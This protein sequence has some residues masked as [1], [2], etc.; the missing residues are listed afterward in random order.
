MSSRDH[1]VS[2]ARV[3]AVDAHNHLGKWL[4][5]GEWAIHDVDLLLDL[6][7]RCNVRAIVNLDGMWGPVLEEN[8][9]RYDRAHEGR[10]FTFCQLDWH[11]IEASGF[12]ERLCRSL[13]ES[14]GRGARGLKVWKDLG[15]HIRDDDGRLIMPDD[16]R[17]SDVWD[18]AADLQLPVLIHTADPVAFFL[19]VDR[20]NERLEELLEFPE[21]SFAEPTFPRFE[22]LIESLEGLVAAHPRTTFIGAHAGCYAEDL[23]WVGRML[24]AY[25]N[26][27][28]DI[29]A[30]IAELGRQ[31]QATRQLILNHPDRVLF[32]TDIFPP[33]AE[34]YA[35]HFRFLETADE[36]FDYS[37]DEVPPQGRWKIYGV[38]LPED[39][40]E[41]VYSGNAFSVL[42][43]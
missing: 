15:L 10:F 8:L 42:A 17:L 27:N 41:R 39:I 28:I 7:A 2:R 6:M 36:Y 16:D 5:K 14:A 26:F 38:D 25:P 21:W 1:F 32:G 33:T 24:S 31:P 20:H 9:D 3:P 11:E 23:Q 30:R 29:A 12:T 35:I 43:L 13:R 34:D 18:T 40:L 19:P 4:T 22:A 37:T